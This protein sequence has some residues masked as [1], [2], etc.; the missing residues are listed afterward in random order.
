MSNFIQNPIE[1]QS[2]D[3]IQ[4]RDSQIGNPILSL[5]PD[6]V[7]EILEKILAPV[8]DCSNPFSI[9]ENCSFAD[10]SS[11]TLVSINH[12]I[13]HPNIGLNTKKTSTTKTIITSPVSGTFPSTQQGSVA[14]LFPYPCPLFLEFQIPIWLL[15]EIPLN[16]PFLLALIV[17]VPP[18]RKKL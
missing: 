10:P 5:R 18:L 15:I 13:A 14:P 6:I 12:T 3:P 16:S 4:N 17:L 9:L 11:S 2:I 1:P 8:L 7:Y